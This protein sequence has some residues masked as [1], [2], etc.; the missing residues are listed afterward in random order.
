MFFVLFLLGLGLAQDALPPESAKDDKRADTGCTDT[1]EDCA[2]EVLVCSTE[3]NRAEEEVKFDSL[4]LCIYRKVHLNKARPCCQAYVEKN[5]QDDPEWTEGTDY[6]PTPTTEA[7]KIVTKNGDPKA[8]NKQLSSTNCLEWGP[9][10]WEYWTR[11]CRPVKFEKSECSNSN[12]DCKAELQLCITREKEQGRAPALRNLEPC[13]IM[14]KQSD[15]CQ[16]YTDKT[17]SLRGPKRAN[18]PD[19]YDKENCEL[20]MRNSACKNQPH[21]Q[22]KKADKKCYPMKGIRASGLWYVP[23][24]SCGYK[25]FKLFFTE[26]VKV[27]KRNVETSCDCALYCEDY[28]H[29]LWRQATSK[30]GCTDAPVRK[31]AREKKGFWGSDT[32]HA[33]RRETPD[34]KPDGG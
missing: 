12:I 15:C 13:V 10:R 33:P 34:V 6:T 2:D 7:E 11:V 19:R 29:W 1:H 27:V 8:C 14:N 5:Q 32:K 25:N 21:C 22:W 16:L 4:K 31:V 9:C 24:M 20:Y 26:K 23:E 28:E 30:C 18:R 3:L 17:L